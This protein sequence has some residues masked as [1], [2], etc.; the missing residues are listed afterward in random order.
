MKA[1][2]STA[3]QIVAILHEAAAGGERN[4]EQEPGTPLSGT[5]WAMSVRPAPGHEERWPGRERGSWRSS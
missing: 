4:R 2:R 3:E 1:S 5:T